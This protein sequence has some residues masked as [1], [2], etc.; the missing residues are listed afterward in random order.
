[1]P[2]INGQFG[3]YRLDQI[4]G[5]GGMGEVYRAYDTVHER[6]VAIK[7]LL[8]SL[9]ADPDYRARFE[10]EA[11]IAAGLREQHIIPIHRFGEIDG[12]L[13]IDMRLVDGE[14]LGKVLARE[15][16]LAPR[17]AVGILAQLAAAL[18]AAHQANLIHRDIKPANVLLADHARGTSDAVYL[19]D[20]GIARDS[21]AATSLTVTGAAVG[22]PDYMAPERFT[23]GRIDRRA[24]IY[25]LGCLFY[26]M[27]AGSKP[28]A[29]GEY[30]ALLY[31]HLNAEP[32]KPS[33]AHTGVPVA[34]DAVVARSMAKDPE[35]RFA[36]AGELAA[37][38][39]AALDGGRPSLVKEELTT[40]VTR[41]RPS[42][43][44]FPP[45][46]ARHTP[47]PDRSAHT[48]T[49]DRSAYTPTPG[50]AAYTASG[51]AAYGAAG[52]TPPPSTSAYTPPPGHS[53]YTPQPGY[54]PAHATA[55]YTP[56]PGHGGYP[57][58]AGVGY[59]GPSYPTPPSQG[60]NGFAIA[61]LIFGVIGGALL[62]FIFGFI[63]LS[64]TKRTG[65]NGRGM[66]IA[67]IVLSALWT[68]GILLLIVVAVASSAPPEP[69]SPTTFPTATA[70]PTT[71]PPVTSAPS[72]AISAT[73]LQVGDCLNDLTDSTDVSSL[74]SVDCAQPH[75]GEVF[76]V[77]DLPPGPYP[78]A[79]G[80]DDLVSKGCN[81]RLAEYSPG[82]PTDDAVGL[83]SVYP[84]EQNWE[85]GD[86]E[87]VCIA[88][89]TSGTATGSIKG[90]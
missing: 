16:A 7:L 64:Q 82:A 76:A 20:F 4:I 62:G 14:D 39:E 58:P 40:P 30:P 34:M 35:A 70:E 86:R 77:F 10:R 38:A 15:G 57:P 31:K 55:A 51:H 65:Q 60:T 27:L 12:R 9:S 11:R 88:K 33:A 47:P 24:D 22:T 50:P 28:F 59:G 61:A 74:P 23:A 49:P 41:S 87:V 29:G 69:V 8:E 48:L 43:G 75:Q 54:S 63:A 67:G 83:F 25:A 73:E 19:V 53:G 2:V 81:A 5:R 90:R 72:T 79:A 78:G 46:G 26:E 68:I 85:R 32:P 18:D 6:I 17:R 80:V 42:T 36:T 45:G 37:A 89:A 1:V 52:T 21:T 13:F 71:E 56:P 66:A 3:P 84:L 44:A